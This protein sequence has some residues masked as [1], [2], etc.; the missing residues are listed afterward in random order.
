VSYLVGAIGLAWEQS[1]P[2]FLQL[3]P[4]FLLFNALMVFNTEFI[5]RNITYWL[6]LIP[7]GLISFYLEAYG[8]SSGNIFGAYTYGDILGIK[9][10]Q[11]PLII[12]LNW[13]MVIWGAYSFASFLTKDKIAKAFITGAA[14]VVFDYILEPVAIAL[15]FWNWQEVKV[16]AQ[17]YL[18][19]FVISFVLGFLAHYLKLKNNTN[20]VPLQLMLQFLLF[21][22]LNIFI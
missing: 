18:A 3:T 7:A 19:W 20:I 8:V 22:S 11:V 4:L 14:C 6:W 16:P 15:G 13:V 10:A 21:L 2:L 12:G 17:N 9:L 5:A 1:R